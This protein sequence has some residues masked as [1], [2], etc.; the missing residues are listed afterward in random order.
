MYYVFRR[1]VHGLVLLIAVSLLSFVM[2]ELAP[3]DFLGDL[4]LD[5]RVSEETMS[6]LRDRYGL[7]EPMPVRYLQWL[8]SS[9]RGDFGF[10][11]AHLTTAGSLLLPRARNTLFLASI[12][13][14]MAWSTAIPLGVWSAYRQGGVLDRLVVGFS[15]FL[16]A[17]PTIVIG[18]SALLLAS[19]LDYFPTGGMTSLDFRELG[20]AGRFSDLVR[21][22]ALPAIA[23]ALGGFPVV[24]RH[25]R[26]ALVEIVDAPLVKA[27]R[28][29]GI[30][31]YRLLFR[32]ALKAAA[33]PLISLFGLS[34]GGL[35][36]G[37][38]LIEVIMGWPGLGPLLLQSIFARD[39]HVVIGAVLLSSVFLIG[40]NLLADLLLFW[41][42]PRT[43]V[44][45]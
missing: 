43:R 24:Y 10:S 11:K 32:Q 23:L 27:A 9:L 3:G 41:I 31:T 2:A 21:H 8:E 13:L 14:I 36:S 16:L 12:A 29:Q 44:V 39:A 33:N 30:G 20:P 4:R 22:L 42:D 37:S 35:L 34:I 1:L 26:T 38:L 40:G 19:R 5:H 45:R 7:D 18:L 6:L 17:T 15:S 25:A 28:G